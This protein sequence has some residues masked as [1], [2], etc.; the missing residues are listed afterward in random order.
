MLL[1]YG[2]ESRALAM[3]EEEIQA[4]R[5]AVMPEWIALFDELDARGKRLASNELDTTNTAKTVRVRDGQTLVT[6]GP[7]AETKEQLGGYFLL[8]CENLDE[9]IELAAKVPLAQRGTIEVRPVAE[10]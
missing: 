2:D 3:T 4:A 6:D 1:V 5:A 7:Y 8:E 10:R 9:A